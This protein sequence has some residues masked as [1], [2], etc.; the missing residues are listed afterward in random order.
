VDAFNPR[1]FTLLACVC[2]RCRPSAAFAYCGH[3]VVLAGDSDQQRDDSSAGEVDG[4]GQVAAEHVS[5]TVKMPAVADAQYI[6]LQDV[7][8]AV[9]VAQM[10][11]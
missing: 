8:C 6:E 7:S 3:E 11:F 5:L 4:Q 10:L 9:A 2:L 1:E